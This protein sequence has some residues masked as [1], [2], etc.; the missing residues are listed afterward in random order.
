MGI[1][2]D[3]FQVGLKMV[4]ADVYIDHSRRWTHN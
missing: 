3:V 1:L 2:C 4:D